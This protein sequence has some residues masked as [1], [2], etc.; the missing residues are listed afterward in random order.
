MSLNLFKFTKEKLTVNAILAL[1]WVILILSIPFFGFQSKFMALSL[2]QKGLS[3]LVSFLFAFVV[4][5]PLTCSLIFVYK[6]IINSKE[7]EKSS[8]SEL[9]LAL[10]I[11][12][13]WNPFI[14]PGL[15][16]QGV[17]RF[18]QEVINH[19]CG[20]EVTGFSDNSPARDAG[21]SIG[22]KILLADGKP[23]DSLDSFSHVMSLKRPGD[24]V[25]IKTQNKEYNVKVIAGAD[26]QGTVI[27]IKL[28]QVYCK[29]N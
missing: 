17:V 21:M 3:V 14:G 22:E 7:T 24:I 27:G 19:P 16:I 25:V 29:K 5:Y 6:K 1:F 11:I 2:M 23:I 26:D 13:L 18:N 15:I 12:L 4:Y 8:I 9:I 10:L 28:A 20:L